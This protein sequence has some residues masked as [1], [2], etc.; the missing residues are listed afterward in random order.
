MLAL[1]ITALAAAASLPG[2]GGDDDAGDTGTS[3]AKT[4]STGTGTT[5][6]EATITAED[7]GDEPMQSAPSGQESPDQAAPA[8]VFEI[9]E[10][11]VS[12]EVVAPGGAIKFSAWVRG[13]AASVTMTVKGGESPA[14]VMTVP[15]SFSLHAGGGIYRWDAT[16]N[17]PMAPGLYRY[18]ASAVST[19][20]AT[21]EMPG[22]SG[23]SFCVGDPMTD[24][25]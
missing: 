15:L 7:T 18:Y 23:W 12:P 5:S 1:V 21:A 4:G 2:C 10:R 13:D 19:A 8:G 25:G 22:V 11:Q 17:A 6:T 24:C 20:G 16:V 9:T 14:P 3:T